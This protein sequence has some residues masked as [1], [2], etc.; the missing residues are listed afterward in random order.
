MHFILF[1]S[2]LYAQRCTFSYGLWNVRAKKIIRWISI[3]KSRSDLSKQEMGDFGCTPCLEDQKK[4]QLE[5]G[6]TFSVCKNIADDVVQALHHA[7]EQGAPIVSVEG[8]RPTMTRGPIDPQGNRTILSNHAFGTAID[9]N[10]AYNG[11]YDHCIQMNPECRLIQGGEWKPGH[12]NS[13]SLSHPLVIIMKEIGLQWGGEI[14]G[15]QKDMMHFS[16]T[17]Y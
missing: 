15:K 12:P 5:N 13:L 9:V 1:V 8:Y 7:M 3:D 2:T 17:G 11:L 10:R 4:V 6:I 14:Q 16:R